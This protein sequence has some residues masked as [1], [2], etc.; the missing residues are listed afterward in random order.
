MEKTTGRE[1]RLVSQGGPVRHCGVD[2]APDAA[3]RPPPLRRANP[4]NRIPARPAPSVLLLFLLLPLLCLG[5]CPGLS[6]AGAPGPRD[7]DIPAGEAG[8]ALEQFT[9]QSGQNL[10]YSASDLSGVRTGPVRGALEPEEALARLLKGTPLRVSKA[11]RSGAMAIVRDEG[12]GE[13]GTRNQA[14]PPMKE[15]KTLLRPLAMLLALGGATA[16]H[17]QSTD[18][19]AKVAPAATADQVELLPAF[20]VSANPTDSYRATNSSAATRVSGKVM[21][22]G[23]SISVLTPEFLQD[24]DPTRIFDATKYLAG[25][26]EGQG[27]GFY[28]RQYIRGFQNNRPTVDNFASVQSEN[29]DSLFIDHIEVVKGPSA[30]LAPTGTPGGQIN[31]ISKSPSWATSRTFSATVGRSDAQRAE[32]DLTGALSEGSAFAYRVLGGYQDSDLNTSGTKNKRKLVGAQMSWK[33]SD[34]SLLTLRGSYEDRWQFVYFPAYFDPEKSVNGADGVLAPGFRV[35]GSR[36]GTEEWAHRGGRY[37]TADLLFS[38]SVGEHVS[39]RVAAK[40]QNDA[41]RD[42]YM[43][44]VIPYDLSNRYNPYTGQETPDYTWAYDAASAKYVPTYSAYYDPTKLIRQPTK[45]SQDNKDTSAQADIA[46][47]YV[48][49]G[50]TST[51]VMGAALSHGNGSGWYRSATQLP[52]F[53]LYNPNYGAPEA[54]GDI[55]YSYT[56]SS[57]SNQEYLNQQL[58]FLKD[59]LTVTGGVVRVGSKGSSNGVDGDKVSKTIGQYGIVG[60]PLE[61]LTVYASQSQ[62]SV[63]GYPNGTLLWQ[64]GKQTEFG[65]KISLFEERLM[66]TAAHFQISQT[67][68]AV[69]NPRFQSDPNNQPRTLISDIKEHG[70]EF[71]ITGGLTKNLSVVGNMTFLHQRDSLGRHVIMVPDESAALFLNYRFT[72]GALKG[73]SAFVGTTYV[74]RRS[75]EIPQIDFTVLGVV[76]QPSFY[77]PKLQ[78]WNAGAKYVWNKQVTSS[79]NIDNVFNKD[80]IALS[81]GRFL[82]GVGSPLNVRLTTTFHF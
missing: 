33:I 58:G 16:G 46:A 81:S 17:A 39:V 45:P 38:T 10:L 80:Y 35:T 42:A 11:S 55:N 71:E 54:F 49:E 37:S 4:S 36:N 19:A 25:I 26:S 29:A 5:L 66:I 44:G 34:H 53:N 40:S 23:G 73:F 15:Q 52:A 60:K 57:S 3:S 24:V 69:A 79:L 28:D 12:N 76:T 20:S 30:L 62:N 1:I 13:A 56:Q 9:K 78:L 50:V 22:I 32:I 67:N 65:A 77:L 43:Y 21:D 74:G 7:F 41:L 82:G 51:T 8:R 59:K 72:H 6:A 48:F 2:T 14:I 18:Q 31:I 63:P 64:D 61:N 47:K 75:G 68:V 70:T 27:D